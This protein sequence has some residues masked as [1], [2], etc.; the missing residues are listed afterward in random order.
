[1][2]LPISCLRSLLSEAVRSRSLERLE[3]LAQV[4][5]ALSQSS[6]TKE[7]MLAGPLSGMTRGSL[8]NYLKALIDSGEVVKMPGERVE[9][10]TKPRD[11]YRSA[12]SVPAGAH[13][14]LSALESEVVDFLSDRGASSSEEIKLG[15]EA[16]DTSGVY[17]ALRRL[18]DKGLVSMI[19]TRRGAGRGMAYW[20]LTSDKEERRPD[21]LSGLTPREEQI[22]SILQALG[23]GTYL[24]VA[25]SGD[26]DREVTQNALRRLEELGRVVVVGY[27]RPYRSRQEWPVYR[28]RGVTR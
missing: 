26:L 25:R 14:G 18:E 15:V 28:V 4:L 2:N 1:M 16:T 6:L 23:E 5:D 10:G 22:V 24:D 13:V 7:E 19:G 21:G 17:L 12:K 8:D 9:G 20:K 3:K 27:S 11:R